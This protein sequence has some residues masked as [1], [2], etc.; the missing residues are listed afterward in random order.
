MWMKTVQAHKW[1]ENK[2]R[3]S[4]E[5]LGIERE[6]EVIV[7][8]TP[9]TTLSISTGFEKEG[10]LGYLYSQGTISSAKDILSHTVEDDVHRM[11]VSV[12]NPPSQKGWQTKSDGVVSLLNHQIFSLTASFQEKAMLYKHISITQ[13]SAL[14]THKGIVYFA[15]DLSRSMS[16]YK[17]IGQMLQTGDQTPPILL[18]S[19]KIDHWLVKLAASLQVHFIISRLGPTDKAYTTANEHNIALYGFARGTRYTQYLR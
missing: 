8:D 11:T 18:V 16:L 1:D 10:V 17:V 13:S 6:I 15:E 9:T 19:G 7:N 5:S 3:K 4:N 12:Q 14:A 2:H